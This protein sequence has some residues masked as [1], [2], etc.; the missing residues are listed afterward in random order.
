VLAAVPT[1]L[2]LNR[3]DWLNCFHVEFKLSSNQ[4]ALSEEQNNEQR[5]YY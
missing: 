4:Q 3:F 2:E 5:F 1:N